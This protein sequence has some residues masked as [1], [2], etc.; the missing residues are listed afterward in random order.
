MAAGKGV[1]IDARTNIL[2]SIGS[3]SVPER[4]ESGAIEMTNRGSAIL[5]GHELIHATHIIAG[6]YDTSPETQAPLGEHN[7]SENGINYVERHRQEEFRT[8][9]L[10]YNKRGDITENKLRKELGYRPRAVYNPD[11]SEWKV[12]K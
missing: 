7:F 8:V 5:L 3:E 10:G 2:I 4:T 12:R 11:R 1:S 6:S 9:G